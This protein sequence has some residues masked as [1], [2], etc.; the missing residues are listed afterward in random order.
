MSGGC[1]RKYKYG[2]GDWYDCPSENHP[3]NNRHF[4]AFTCFFINLLIYLW[5][6]GGVI[7]LKGK[8]KVSLKLKKKKNS[9]ILIFFGFN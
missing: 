2:T 3:L 4:S 5:G 7:S 1:N 9:Q 8:K 6:G